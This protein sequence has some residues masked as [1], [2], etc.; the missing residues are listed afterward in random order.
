LDKYDVVVIG[1][2]LGGIW[3]RHFDHIS[4]GKHT[5][6]DVLD[7]NVNQQYPIRTVY[8]Q[9]RAAK[10]DYLLN[11]KLALN[12][13]T[14][15][16]DVI[17][18]DKFLPEENAV[19]L[20]NGRRIGYDHLV[21]AMGIPEDYDQIKGFDEAWKD[22]EHPVFAAKDHP[23]WRA[24]L[25]K[26]P[27]YHFNYTSG[28]AYFC[29]PPYP[30][31]GEVG[32][33][34]FFLSSDIWRWYSTNGKLSPIHSLTVVNANDNFCAHFEEAD[35]FIKENL[36]KHKINVE[37]GWN[38]KEVNMQENLATFEN[39]KTKEK[40]QKPYTNL[41]SLPPSKP[42]KSLVDAGLA[43]AESNFL[44]DVDRET[45]RHNKYKNIFGLG[46]VCNI[47]T[48]KTFYGGFHQIH[49]VRHNVWRSL[50]GQTLNAKY[51]GN[52]KSS[53][54][55]GQNQMTFVAHYYDQKPQ[56]GNL[57][58]KNGGI[59]ARLRYYN[60]AKNQKKKFLGYYLFKT[61]GP[62]YGKLKKTFKDSPGGKEAQKDPHGYHAEKK[63]VE[64]T[65]VAKP[66]ETKVAETKPAH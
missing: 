31:K 26:Y 17:G 7:Q 50:H 27:R 5:V 65:Q 11:A 34:N 24:N 39:V 58:G 59:I 55:L 4:K 9:Q 22:A 66:V 35:K 8:E 62:P 10:A 19:V 28:D 44:L 20:R 15:H 40:V 63:T 52:A 3:T 1:C 47:P 57:V 37:Y 16:S 53:L 49:V 60:W 6:M 48:T 64:S 54:I 12:M 51:D 42:H 41:Y 33:L 46:D 32:G 29:I 45:L 18:V 13:Y 43:T 36:K 2:N 25:H 23:T 56:T 38:L 61:W 30:Y 21:V 14:A